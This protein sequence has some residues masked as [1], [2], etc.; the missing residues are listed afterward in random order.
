L[1]TPALQVDRL[2]KCSLNNP[3]KTLIIDE[4]GFNDRKNAF[5][6]YDSN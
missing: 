5:L 4:F 2:K 6:K 3:E 1:P